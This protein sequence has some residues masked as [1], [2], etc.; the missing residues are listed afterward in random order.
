[1]AKVSGLRILVACFLASV[2][3]RDECEV[4]ETNAFKVIS[5]LPHTLAAFSSAEDPL[6]LCATADLKYFSKH[7]GKLGYVIHLKGLNG[8]KK[9]DIMFHYSRTNRLDEL[10]M[11]INDDTDHP[12][13]A[14][15]LYS[16]FVTCS[17]FKFRSKKE[18]CIM[19]VARGAE[20]KIN[21]KCIKAF[22]CACGATI[23]LYEKSICKNARDTA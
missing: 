1:M 20:D 15:S 14:Q 3:G 4:D 18:Q 13:I 11:V 12:I 2:S 16:D 23:P 8:T 7:A 5:Q 6:L 9:Q 19:W 21:P 10:H 17:V 22:E